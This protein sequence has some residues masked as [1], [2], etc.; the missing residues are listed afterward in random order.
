M[1]NVHLWSWCNM[2]VLRY[3]AGVTTSHYK[4]IRDQ[5]SPVNFTCLHCSQQAS[6]A[7]ISCLNT[8]IQ[9]LKQT[10]AQV[11]ATLSPA[12]GETIDI[13]QDAAATQQAAT[14]SYAT[15]VQA[16]SSVRTSNT[17]PTAAASI[18]L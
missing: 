9:S 13:P 1:I 14:P 8:E 2:R 5:S 3:C 6:A 12:Q 17:I 16:N 10:V 4:K 11:I 7:E 15:V 18:T